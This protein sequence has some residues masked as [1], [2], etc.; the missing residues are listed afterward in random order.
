V[1]SLSVFLVGMGSPR[2][3]QVHAIVFS[4]DTVA[5]VKFCRYQ[6][7]KKLVTMNID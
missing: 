4:K 3:Q 2:L 6:L 7:L 1:Y 5:Y